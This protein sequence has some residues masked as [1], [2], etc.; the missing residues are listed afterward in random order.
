[1]PE[2][3]VRP[4]IEADIP[5][6]VKI[7][8]SYTSDHVWQMDPFFAPDQTG[9]IF[10]EVRLPRTAKV[11]YPRPPQ[12]LSGLWKTYSGVLVAVYSGEPVGYT[13]LAENVIPLTTWAVDL[14]VRPNLR[15]KGIG[16]ALLLAALEW[17]EART[18]SHRLMLGMQPKNYPGI[19]L[20]LRLGFDYCG[21]IDHYF[22]NRDI[23]IFFTKWII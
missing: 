6:L 18:K 2:I 4:A 23:A 9:A 1:M 20:A 15:R 17:T 8:H 10:R 22:P 3:E 7:D 21:Y 16:T 13:S 14:V 19:N 11:D 5:T 12:S